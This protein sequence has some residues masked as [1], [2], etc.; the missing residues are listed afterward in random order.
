M[1][2]RAWL[3][4]GVII[5]AALATMATSRKSWVVEATLPPNDATKARIV[6][7]E[8]SY[9]PEVST[10]DGR[11]TPLGPTSWP[12][13]G[14]FLVRSG[15]AIT[16]VYVS[17]KCN[18]SMCKKCEAPRD[19]KVRVVSID[20]VETWTLSATRAPDQQPTQLEANKWTRYRIAV[21]SSH[22]AHLTVKSSRD[23]YVSGWGA[24]FYVD[25]GIVDVP[26]SVTWSV[27]ATIEEPCE[28]LTKSCAQPAGA[29]VNITSIAR[30]VQ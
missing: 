18:G 11:A 26:T 20:P 5:I 4:R 25:L 19:A 12:G 15:V 2:L 23:A 14:R 7:V 10:A 9:V 8:A 28:D 17:E 1:K 29:H 16:Q 27:T 3:D 30:E 13:T 22:P 21:D 24:E 6:V